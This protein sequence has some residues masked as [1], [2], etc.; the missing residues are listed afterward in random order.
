MRKSQV[1]T[2][3]IVV[4]MGFALLFN[5]NT[6]ALA[7]YSSAEVATHNNS[8]SCWM[9]FEN[10]VYDLT[11]YYQSHDRYMDISSWCGNDMTT[12]FQTKAGKGMDH[13]SST[14][15]LLAS[16]QIGTLSSVAATSTPSAT[17]TP[18]VTGTSAAIS[19]T[20]TPTVSPSVTTA[21]DTANKTN[22]DPYNFPV[23][24]LGTLLI[25]IFSY[26]LF[27]KK[28]MLNFNFFWNSVMV[29][30]LIPSGIFG[31]YM[32]LRYSF[33]VLY[34]IN[35]DFLFWHVE[36]SIIFATLAAAHLLQRIKQ[37]I[38]PVKVMLIRKK[39]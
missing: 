30:S 33:S 28:Y 1:V 34:Q 5:V 20:S 21:V 26:I 31:F 16:F 29:L 23:L 25:Y 7:T 13:K 14:Y 37:Y 19:A 9:S 8:S 12:D 17:L 18:A 4:F 22:S 39:T 11:S 38:L 3:M 2:A 27:K 35:F 10:G 24:F 36:G 6:F 32:I 15:N